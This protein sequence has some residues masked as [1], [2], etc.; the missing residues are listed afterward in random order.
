MDTHITERAEIQ[1]EEAEEGLSP[2]QRGREAA[3]RSPFRRANRQEPLLSETAEPT[4]RVNGR[5]PL[6]PETSEPALPQRRGRN[7]LLATTCGVVVLVAAGGV[8][9]IS[10]Y[11][12]HSLADIKQAVSR[13]QDAAE[14][15][16]PGAAPPAPVAPAARLARAPEP[17]RPAALYRAPAAINEAS[18]RGDDMAEFL[19]LGGRAAQPSSEANG[20]AAIAPMATPRTS[21]PIGSAAPAAPPVSATPQAQPSVPLQAH[22]G[23]LKQSD[24]AA[25]VPVPAQVPT[26][27]VAA[28]AALRPAPMTEPQQ[29]QVL[30]LVTQLGTLIRDQRAEIVQLRQDQ[31]NVGQHVDVALADFG[32]RVSLAEARRAVG[33]A[34]QAE[35]GAV[36]PAGAAGGS[37]GTGVTPIVARYPLPAPPPANT[38]PHRYHVQAAS[39]GLAMLSE[40]DRSGGE[41]RQL[42]VSPGD[43]V[44]GWGKV[45]SIS[46]RGTTWMVKTDHGLI[47]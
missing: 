2:S 38:G 15:T 12:H 33:A 35:P 16:L 9:W 19:K 21:S 29:V 22:S 40:L 17:S 30:E 34:G 27:A 31:Q 37:S 10:P 4:L 11:N 14:S 25:Q 13:V 24:E 23:A 43:D 26:D 41:E 18:Q 8:F 20:E 46:Q 42:P 1:V 47:Q 28:V 6:P 5:G 36:Q 45:V 32:R 3:R 7:G 44:P 39:P